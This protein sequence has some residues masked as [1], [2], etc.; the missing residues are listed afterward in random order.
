F[1]SPIPD[2]SSVLDRTVPVVGAVRV[3]PRQFGVGRDEAILSGAARDRAREPPRDLRTND[4]AHDPTADRVA[5]ANWADRLG[6]VGGALDDR[7]ARLR[8]R[9]R[10][11]GR[12]GAP[13]GARGARGARGLPTAARAALLFELG[14]HRVGRAPALVVLAG[15]VAI[16]LR[17]GDRRVAPLEPFSVELGVH[18]AHALVAARRPDVLLDPG[19]AL[20]ELDDLPVELEY[21]VA[22]E[23]L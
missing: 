19:R 7:R 9:G 17:V 4:V 11:R 16:T 12:L 21:L 3:E 8:W 18:L 5:V 22:R 2:L 10:G 14:Q 20:P 15:V 6:R 23:Q 13:R 1:R